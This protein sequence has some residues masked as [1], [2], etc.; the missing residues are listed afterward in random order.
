[1]TSE[2]KIIISFVF[3]RSGKQKLK[4][5]DIYLSLSMDLNWF[6]PN[7]AKDFVKNALQKNLLV[8]KNGFIEP[9]FD[10]KSINIPTGFFPSGKN[11]FEI[12]VKTKKDADFFDNIIEF[13]I[14]KTGQKREN[15]L[16]EIVRISV[17][18]N[19][20]QEV[21]ALLYAKGKNIDLSGFF[22]RVEKTFFI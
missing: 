6:T 5:N 1:M 21:A 4:E 22:D 13:I 14:E 3:K 9:G 19:I 2:E 11:S 10:L 7:T 17:E 15:V 16:D 8:E 20:Q 12:E 18:K